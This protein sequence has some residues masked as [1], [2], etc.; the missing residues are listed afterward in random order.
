[1]VK[2][3]IWNGVEKTLTNTYIH[4]LVHTVHPFRLWTT[5][6]VKKSERTLWTV[7]IPSSVHTHK[8]ALTV[9]RSCAWAKCRPKTYLW[10]HVA[11]KTYINYCITTPCLQCCRFTCSP[12]QWLLFIIDRLSPLRVE[13]GFND[14]SL[15]QWNDVKTVL[16]FFSWQSDLISQTSDFFN[17]LYT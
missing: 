15:V 4:C 8:A 17:T 5:L 7:R 1:M 3:H 11:S 6:S 13:T 9:H 16:K 14:S 2:V 10:R 12:T